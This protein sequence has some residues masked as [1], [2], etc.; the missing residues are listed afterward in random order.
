MRTKC[1][2]S[3]AAALHRVFVA[4]IIRPNHIR[5]CITTQCPTRIVQYSVQ[6]QRCYAAPS[7]ERRLPR[8]DQIRSWSVVLVNDDG[9]LEDPRSKSDVLSSLDRDKYTLAVVDPGEPGMP[10]I[11][12]ILEKKALREAE[13]AKKAAKNP[14]ATSKTIE[15]NWAIDDNDAGHRINKIKDFLNKGYKVEVIMAKKRRGRKPTLEQAENLVEK[16]KEAVTTVEGARETKPM[17]GKL[18][19]TATIFLEGKSHK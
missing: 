13:K 18:M 11:C 12:K 2:F 4:P 15:L 5:T 3:S 1:M 10:P 7:S 14:A 6:Q 19:E 8:D 9:K 17:D 16:I